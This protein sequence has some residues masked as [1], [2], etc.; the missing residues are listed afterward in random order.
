MDK[1]EIS[2]FLKGI[3]L[4]QGIP[5]EDFEK[6]ADKFSIQKYNAGEIILLE[7]T[8]ADALYIIVSGIVDVLKLGES[9]E[10]N[11]ELLIEKTSGD[12]FGEMSIM[13]QLPRSASI[14]AKSQSVLLLRLQ[15]E[16]FS[17][18]CQTYP[19]MAYSVA[20]RIS[21]IVREANSRYVASLETRNRAL[22]KAYQK[23]Q[24]A[25]NELLNAEKLSA[26]GKFASI[27]IHDIK[28][29]LTNIRAYAELIEKKLSKV[30]G[31]NSTF[32]GIVMLVNELQ[33][34]NAD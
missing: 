8:I 15:K 11:E 2:A 14:R 25:Q 31:T 33:P 1:D 24:E 21:A 6:I 23:L 34:L 16:E 27:I 9:S 26:I 10:F 29:P 32:L 3:T 19:C 17:A 13:D 4:F 22:E 28:N 7:N 30:E 20:K 12:F 18:M 5:D